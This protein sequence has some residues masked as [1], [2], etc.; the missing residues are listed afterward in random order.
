[1]LNRGWLA[2]CSS[3]ARD[4]QTGTKEHVS[5]RELLWGTLV[6]S[7]ILFLS[8]V[9]TS[10][11]SDVPGGF[12]L[13]SF[14]TLDAAAVLGGRGAREGEGVLAIAMGMR[15][16][17][18]LCGQHC[19]LNKAPLLGRNRGCFSLGIQS[20]IRIQQFQQCF[21]VYWVIFLPKTT[22]LVQIPSKL[23]LSIFP[24]AF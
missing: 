23:L 16:F 1:M 6:S 20:Q 18:G 17:P 9:P 3:C 8:F 5:R 12:E 24:T 21:L 19:L 22:S 11:I 10:H 15:C 13:W 2:S 14:S 4:P 7:Q